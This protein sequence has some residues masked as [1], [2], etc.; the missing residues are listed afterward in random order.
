MKP[1]RSNLWNAHDDSDQGVAL[2]VPQKINGGLGAGCRDLP[3]FE[4]AVA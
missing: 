1:P 3:T 2:A 4:P